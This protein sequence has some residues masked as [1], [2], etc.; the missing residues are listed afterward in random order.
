MI[1]YSPRSIRSQ[2]SVMT[3]CLLLILAALSYWS[4]HMYGNRAARLSYDRLMAGAALQVAES[5]GIQDGEVIVDLPQAAFET[6]SLATDDRVFYA[7]TT[8]AGDHITGYEKLPKFDPHT[9]KLTQLN[10]RRE[11]S[12]QFFDAYYSNEPVRFVIV[13]RVLNDVGITLEVQIQ[14]GQTRRASNALS[15]DISWRVLQFVTFFSVLA[16]VLIMFGI[17]MLLRPLNQLNIAL[18]ERSHVD[19]SPLDL[20]VPLE[21]EPLLKTI[22]HFMEQLAATLDRLKRFTGEAAHQIRTPLAGLK[23]QAQ[24]ALEEHDPLLR[25]QQLKRVVE[26]SDLLSGTVR[27]MLN[28][29]K[30]AYR[31]QSEMF[32]S[33]RLDSLIKEVCRDVAVA[34]LRSDVEVV[35]LSAV[36]I[37]VDG[38]EF[39]LKQMIRNILENAIKYSPRGGLVAVD[40]VV[41]SAPKGKV[42]AVLQVSDSGPGIPENERSHVFEQF[43]R[44]PNNKRSGS[45]LGLSI[46]REVAEHHHAKL[47][48]KDNQP[49]G[50]I[51]EIYFEGR[52]VK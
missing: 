36:E 50:L 16:L 38:D 18:S 42:S 44:S 24:N 26:C 23:S 40:L 1:S 39:A 2:L 9:G 28:Q 13:N 17:W 31:F 33:I 49:H 35:Y 10:G 14:I 12:P 34:A 29:A 41:C 43:Y 25:E 5:I 52:L 20:Q 6:L 27:Q 37:Y 47:E 15:A 51:V 21:V 30:L 46:A 19:L 8:A 45:G 11:L 22:N 7:I 3:V 48:L 4:A 32:S